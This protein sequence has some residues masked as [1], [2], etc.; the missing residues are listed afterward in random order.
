[1]PRRPPACPP[2]AVSESV[3]L[4]GTFSRVAGA[5]SRGCNQPWVPRFQRVGYGRGCRNGPRP[6]PPV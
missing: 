4:A 1:M 5:A 3:R 2:R 6:I